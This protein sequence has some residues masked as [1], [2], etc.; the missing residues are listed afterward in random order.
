MTR[1]TL[2]LRLFVLMW[3]ALVVSHVAAYAVFH[4]LHA[5]PRAA[6]PGA[7]PPPAAQPGASPPPAGPGAPPPQ[8]G[9]PPLPTFP[10]LPPTP[11]LEALRGGAAQPQLPTPAL[12]LDYGVRLV[13]IALA[14]WWG[15]RWLAR[16]VARLVAAAD[17]LGPALGRGEDPPAL[18]E[19][20]GSA[21]VR[22]A[23]T[24]FNAMARQIRGLFD[25]RGLMIAAIS[26]DL[27]TPLTRLRMRLE[28]AGV[29]PVLRQRCAA[30]VEQMNTL[31][32]AVLEVFRPAARDAAQTQRV[33]LA[34][35]VQALVDDLVE[36]GQPVTLQAQAVVL[37]T[38][39]LA[40][41]RIV[42]N[43]VGNALRYGRQAELSLRLQDAE[44]VLAVDDQ[45]PGIPPGQLQQVLQP[46]VRLEASRSRSTGGAGLG[47]YI[48]QALAERLGGRIGLHNRAGGGLRAEL[49]L[50]LDR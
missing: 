18:D 40:V 5:P 33:D 37:R 7:S 36:Q 46:F 16:P 8:R 47:L 14:A 4:V 28:T 30:D 42:D 19:Q 48:A 29:D 10:S 21:E 50:P 39:P 41:R 23:A 35:L 34:A 9:G 27:R 3:V 2:A 49:R 11:G 25:A 13:L 31:I 24:V 22:R 32:D 17:R 1:D 15:S 26:H 45:G 44:A 12:L 6:H 38:E 43:L 20:R